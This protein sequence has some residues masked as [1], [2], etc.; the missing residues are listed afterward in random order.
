MYVGFKVT[1]VNP[2]EVG[3]VLTCAPYVTLPIK[4]ALSTVLE[5]NDFLNLST[6]DWLNDVGL[7]P[8]TYTAPDGTFEGLLCS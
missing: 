3:C 8:V 7:S 5:P 2:D 4:G 1:R 6:L